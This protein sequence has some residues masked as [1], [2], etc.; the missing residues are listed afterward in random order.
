M[1]QLWLMQ[2]DRN[3]LLQRIAQEVVRAQA[4]GEDFTLVFVC[5]HNSRRSQLCQAWFWH[6][7]QRAGLDVDIASAG[8]EVTACNARTVAALR[9]AGFGVLAEN[10]TV[11]NPTFLLTDQDRTSSS[12]Y[13]FSKTLNHETLSNKQLIAIMTCD[14][15]DENCPFIPTAIARIPLRYKDPK[16]ADDTEHEPKAYDLASDTIRNEMRLLVDLIKDAVKN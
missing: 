15:A 16:H 8:T 10:D 9:R 11:D 4:I 3:E 13:L 5:T 14:H 12:C 7:A 6:Y 2:E 1:T